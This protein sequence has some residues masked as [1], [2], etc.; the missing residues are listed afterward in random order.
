[1]LILRLE[2]A[3]LIHCASA[4]YKLS[5]VI[6]A[7]AVECAPLLNLGRG[8]GPLLVRDSAHFDE[9]LV[10]NLAFAGLNRNRRVLLSRR[11]RDNCSADAILVSGLRTSLLRAQACR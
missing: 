5:V 8:R 4:S 11:D 3:I 9:D 1:M 10:R 2:S 7:D 6:A